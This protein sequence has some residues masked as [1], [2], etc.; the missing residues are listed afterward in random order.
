M[1]IEEKIVNLKIK[2][3]SQIKKNESYEKLYKT[4]SEIDK[5][6]VEYYKEYGLNGVK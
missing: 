2:L 4:S 6:I 3:E 1:K 5:L